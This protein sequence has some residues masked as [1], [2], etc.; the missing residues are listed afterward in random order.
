[1]ASIKASISFGFKQSPPDAVGVGLA[2]AVRDA[3]VR[4]TAVAVIEIL[5]E[6]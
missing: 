6:A 4:L 5:D 3:L 1:M 2:T